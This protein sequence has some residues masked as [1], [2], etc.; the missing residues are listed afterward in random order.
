MKGPEG[1]MGL[2][3]LPGVSMNSKHETFW[4]KLFD[5]KNKSVISS[6][7]IA[8]WKK[9]RRW[10]KGRARRKWNSRYSGTSWID[11]LARQ[12]RKTWEGR[13]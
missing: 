9:R 8:A 2:T 11:G 3:G 4:D 10:S 12:R 5:A 7:R 13:S 6:Y 1:A